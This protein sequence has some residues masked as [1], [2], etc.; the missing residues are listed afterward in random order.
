ME[1]QGL[2][3]KQLEMSKRKLETEQEFGEIP[4]VSNQ[5]MPNVREGEGQLALEESEQVLNFDLPETIQGK[6]RSDLFQAIEG[7]M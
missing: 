1:E 7:K 6:S 5:P 2:P 3:L 4:E